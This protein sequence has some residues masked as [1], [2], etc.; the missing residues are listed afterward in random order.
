MTPIEI[1][2][3]L[4]E[5]LNELGQQNEEYTQ[6]YILYINAVNKYKLEYA[7]AYLQNKA[8]MGKATVNEIDAA[9]TIQVADIKLDADIQEALLK[10]QRE[11]LEAL[12]IEIDTLRSVL[13]FQK[14][15]LDRTMN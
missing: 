6:Q 13:S 3:R 15:E 2:D 11:K 4:M 14:S 9:T 1:N 5:L 12:K 10:A 7:K 8:D